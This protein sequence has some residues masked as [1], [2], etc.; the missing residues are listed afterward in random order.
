MERLSIIRDDS[1]SDVHVVR[2]PS[3][4][5][6]TGLGSGV[7]MVL[8]H[9][10]EPT[11]EEEERRRERIKSKHKMP[12]RRRQE[13]LVYDIRD[14]GNAFTYQTTVETPKNTS[15]VL[16]RKDPRGILRYSRVTMHRAQSRRVNKSSDVDPE[17]R[18]KALQ[19]RVAVKMELK[20]E[21]FNLKGDPDSGAGFNEDAT[22]NRYAGAVDIFDAMDMEED[23]DYQVPV[24]RD[25]IPDS[26]DADADA[27]E[28]GVNVSTKW[29]LD[30][31]LEKEYLSWEDQ[32]AGIDSEGSE[33]DDAD[34][35]DSCTDDEDDDD[36]SDEEPKIRP[37]SS[38]RNA[39]RME[40]RTVKRFYLET[41]RFN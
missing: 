11:E 28:Q 9:A 30:K 31:L 19:D 4:M 40:A 13:A 8:K 6:L 7:E 15:Y 26:T 24:A 34:L 35:S 10:P 20:I 38:K 41:I 18:Q 37:K 12:Y 32:D 39:D 27:R 1:V 2:M 22:K 16:F 5:S 29:E 17:V 14:R 36:E 3:A 21:K 33:I 25:V 23:E